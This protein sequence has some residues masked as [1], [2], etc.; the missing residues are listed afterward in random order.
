MKKQNSKKAGC[1]GPASKA[2]MAG[3]ILGAVAVAFAGY[4]L[5]STRRRK[6]GNPAPAFGNLIE[7]RPVLNYKMFFG[8]A[9]MAYK[10]A[11]A[12]PK[13]ID[14]QFCYCYCKRN[15][16]HK[17][18]LTCFTNTHGSKCGIC[19]NEALYAYELYQDGWSL[20]EIVAAVEKKFYRP[21]RGHR[22]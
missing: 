10:A 18:L 3:S 7:N 9:A 16:Q 12:I 22:L 1:G 14:S 19:M 13:V 6:G 20:D 8:K 2:K 4:Q 11:A 17:T 15:H 5:L 21:Y